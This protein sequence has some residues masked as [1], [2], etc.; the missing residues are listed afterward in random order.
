MKKLI[1]ILA[2]LALGTSTRA[3]E[4]GIRFG[5]VLGNNVALDGLISVGE[6][7]RVHADLSF[8]SGLGVEALYDFLYKPLGNDGFKWYV[9]AGPSMYIDDPFFLGFSGELGLDYH[10]PTVPISLSVDWRPTFWLIEETD[11]RWEG[12]GFNAR[13][14]FGKQ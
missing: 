1:L 2:L 9:G 14:V 11:V 7:S 8:G 12:F 4:L 6:F 3:Q 13:Y 5:D 10:F